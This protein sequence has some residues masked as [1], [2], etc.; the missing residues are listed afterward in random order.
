VLA[1]I[2]YRKRIR[3]A[4]LD[5]ARLSEKKERRKKKLLF[6]QQSALQ[7]HWRLVWPF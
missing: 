5:L 4:F 3:K 6:T 1:K 7:V 2:R